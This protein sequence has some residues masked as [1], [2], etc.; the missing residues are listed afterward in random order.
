M[1]GWLTDRRRKKLEEAPFPAEW[2]AHLDSNVV[3]AARL[4]V[5]MQ[6]RL[7]DLT[8]VFIDEKG[9]EGCGGLE[10]TDEVRV[11]VAAQACLLLLGREHSLYEDVETILVYPS[12]MMA[13]GRRDGHVVHEEGVAILGQAHGNGGPVILAWDDVLEGGREVGERNVVIH[14]FAHKIDMV[15]GAVDGTPPLP[16]RAA[17][18]TWARVCSEAFLELQQRVEA[19]K[20]TFIDEYGATNEAEFFAVASEH[21]WCQP[22]KL[23]RNEP[24]L[25]ELLRAF[26]QFDP[27]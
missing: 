10:M 15:D 7:R 6:E 8:A 22:K 27:V 14:E 24:E 1:L 17:R 5:A 20:R 3:M 11:T 16:D 9:W 18:E 26:Y 25:F 12:T 13:P 23:E 2:Q 4:D 19:G 21:Y